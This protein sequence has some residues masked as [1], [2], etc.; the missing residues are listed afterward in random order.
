MFFG[1]LYIEA[2]IFLQ[3]IG[4]LMAQI[5]TWIFHWYPLPREEL[6]VPPVVGLLPTRP[7]PLL[8]HFRFI[9]LR[10][11]PL[12]EVRP[13]GRHRLVCRHGPVQ[14]LPCHG[15]RGVQDGV[16]GAHVVQ[17]DP[18]PDPPQLQH[19]LPRDA[20]QFPPQLR[21]RGNR[22]AIARL[23]IEFS[24]DPEFTSDRYLPRMMSARPQSNTWLKGRK[25]STFIM[26]SFDAMI[27][28]TEPTE[29]QTQT[30]LPMLRA[31]S[32]VKSGSSKNCEYAPTI[33][34][35]L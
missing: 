30:F 4:F 5:P 34:W 33:C 32:M 29:R 27:T 3:V 13:V 18:V 2:G 22:S 35:S 26:R 21:L 28:G 7:S 6:H 25:V 31:S 16:L 8:L 10:H 23:W 1:L 20:L 15:H 24:P 14:E 9:L 17:E 12:Q 11:P 19:L